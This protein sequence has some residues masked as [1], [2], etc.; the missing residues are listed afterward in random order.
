MSRLGEWWRAAMIAAALALPAAHARAQAGLPDTLIGADG[1]L[2]PAQQDDLRSYLRPLTADL[3]SGEPDRLSRARKNLVRLTFNPNVSVAFRNALSRELE[4]TLRSM[5]RDGG[6]AERINALSIAGEIATIGT[7]NM[8]ADALAADDAGERF[9]AA[10]GIR[11]SFAAV[12]RAP[13]QAIGRP[14]VLDLVEALAS[15][16]ATEDDPAVLDAIVRAIDAAGSIERPGF[17]EIRGPAYQAL[18]NAAARRILSLDGAEPVSGDM[19]RSWLRAI[20]ACRNALIVPA[21]L[22]DPAR[23]SV[24]RLAGVQLRWAAEHGEEAGLG[25]DTRGELV[26][27]LI[28]AAENTIYLMHEPATRSPELAQLADRGRWDELRTGV[29]DLAG[30]AGVLTRPPFRVP[31]G[32]LAPGG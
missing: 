6:P 3:T 9:A 31:P 14:R 2:T 8:L 19:L 25:D 17:A 18:G 10:T 12:D 23:R 30:P 28:A 20:E 5:L 11:S 32:D 4:P 13:G 29:G 1:A 21:G 15:R 16:L 7:A 27:T 22:G 24:A 26:R